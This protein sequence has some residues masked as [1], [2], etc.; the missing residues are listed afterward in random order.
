MGKSTINVSKIGI[1]VIGRNEGERLRICLNS[2]LKFCSNVIYVD[3]GS[4]DGSVT[5]AK[6][7]GAIVVKLDSS[8]PFSASRARNAGV[9]ALNPLKNKLKYVQ[10][11]DG[12]CE[13]N[14][15]WMDL[16]QLFLEGHSNVAVV[17]GRLRERY[18]EKSVYN[19]LCDA[20]W[21]APIGEVM[22]C[23]GL[24]M[25]RIDVFNLLGGFRDDVTS[26]EEPELCMRIRENGLKIWRLE[27]EMALHDAAMF[28]FSQWWNRNRRTGYG[29]IDLA[30]RFSHPNFKRIV[31]RAMFW[32]VWTLMILIIGTVSLFDEREI[33][34]LLLYLLIAAWPINILR[35]ALKTWSSGKSAK[36]SFIYSW[37]MAIGVWPQLLGIASYIGDRIH[38]RQIRLIEHKTSKSK[39][40][41]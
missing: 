4:N 30:I 40:I 6:D 8:I 33:F 17:S 5:L 31:F 12:D 23:G 9:L 37:Y 27:N 29:S 41:F 35:V 24:A 18:P 19:L 1:V 20:E 32:A 15:K 2:V 13:I 11:V 25:M 3:S 10:F 22:S 26:G 38:Q 7:L 36:F 34:N 14:N 28:H 39:N 16:A 21:E